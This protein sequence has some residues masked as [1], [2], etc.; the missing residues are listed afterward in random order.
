M[1]I[2]SGES[3]V[4]VLHTPREKLLGVLDEISPA[5]I[6]VRSV[7]LSYFDDWC[8][9]IANG[10]PYLPMTDSFVPMWRVEKLSRD[11]G[12]EDSPSLTEQ[13][14]RRTGRE[15]AEF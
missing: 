11:A 3:V 7:D 1:K 4:V 6:S 5:G 14:R 15:L 10:E 8:S 12:T 2:E 13:F 9:S